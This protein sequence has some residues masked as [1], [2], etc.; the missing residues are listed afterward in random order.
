[1]NTPPAKRSTELMTEDQQPQYERSIT[2][3]V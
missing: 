1:V 2:A 3:T